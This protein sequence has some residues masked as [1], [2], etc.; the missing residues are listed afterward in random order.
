MY[1]ENNQV[2]HYPVRIVL[3][4]TAVVIWM[5]V[6]FIFSHQTGSQSGQL[7][8]TLARFLTKIF[9]RPA[10]QAAIARFEG[11]LRTLA[12]GGIF[13]IL[14][15]LTCWAFSE[16]S[17]AH[18]RNA[19]LTFIVCALYAASDELHQVFIPGR[20][21]QWSDYLIDMIGVVVAIIFYQLVSTI[22]YLRQELAVKREEDLRL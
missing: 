17:S 5:A 20:A 10:D 3:A 13:F 1:L 11:V 16:T 9:Q 19:L 2:K 8:N 6:I 22:I 18:L 7:S 21:G 4:W 12:H 15:L 14:A